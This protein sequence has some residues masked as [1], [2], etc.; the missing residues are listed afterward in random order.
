MNLSYISRKQWLLSSLRASAMFGKE[1]VK[2]STCK[3]QRILYGVMA[4][5]QNF[6]LSYDLIWWS[7]IYRT[8]RQN[9]TLLSAHWFFH[10]GC[11]LSAW[12]TCRRLMAG[13]PMWSVV[14][15]AVGRG[16]FLRSVHSLGKILLA[17]ALLHF[18]LQ[19]KICP[20]LQVSWFPTLARQ[21]PI[22]KRT[23]LLGVS[24]SPQIRSNKT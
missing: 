2:C 22:M 11:L 18:V 1:K 12:W 16:C 10:V 3:R 14:S 13:M 24:S 4:S 7:W 8:R 6:S 23:S 19:G 9:A 20:W 5:Q 15:Y 21:S 17:F